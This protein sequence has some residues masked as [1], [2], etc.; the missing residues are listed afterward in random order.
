MA[1]LLTTAF[2]ELLAPKDEQY[3]VGDLKVGGLRICIY[4]SG[5]RSWVVRFRFGGVQKK[6]TI[7]TFPL[8]SLATARKRAQE[9]I[10]EIAKGIDPSAVKKASRAALIAKVAEE[11]KPLD[12]IESAAER[13][14]AAHG[15]KQKGL[16][17]RTT[18][19]VARLVRRNILPT[20]KGKRLSAISRADAKRLLADIV[21]DRPVLANRVASVLMMLGKW[22][23]EEE[24]IAQN[25]FAD[26]PKPAKET[27]RDRVLDE[28][29]IGALLQALDAEEDDY[30]Y[31]PLIKLLLL[32][33][34][35]RSEVAEMTWS[36]VDL[37]AKV[38]R[39][40][41]SR[42]KNGIEHTLPLPQAAIDILRGLP[43]F[44]GSDLV[45]STDGKRNLGNFIRIK[46]RLDRRME[47]TLGDAF[48]PWTIHDVRRSFA[49]GLGEIGIQPHIIEACLNHRSGVIKGIARTYNRHPYL[50]EMKLALEAWAARIRE[51]ETGEQAAVNVVEFR[52]N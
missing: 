12:L 47:A 38:W 31:R 42:S 1:R 5:V 21:V 37:N 50:G 17:P 9:A 18:S 35:R 7:G 33:G 13:F 19:E 46:E 48:K 2:I 26:L 52:S 29:E 41:A 28:R 11:A 10:G 34:Q 4:V 36:E 40:P 39:L 30:P 15:S 32:L 14:I 6:L 3:E 20:W 24:V 8:I 43:R 27:P 23:I 16:R 45:F 22:A 51:I 25:P 44:A 49:S